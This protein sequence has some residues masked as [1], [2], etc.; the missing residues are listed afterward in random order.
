MQIQSVFA[1]TN[2]GYLDK[3]SS[4]NTSPLYCRVKIEI[5]FPIF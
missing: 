4:A 5:N 2:N 3:N 1:L